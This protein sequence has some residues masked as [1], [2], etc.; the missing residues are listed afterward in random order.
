MGGSFTRSLFFFPTPKCTSNNKKKKGGWRDKERETKKKK[1]TLM[2]TPTTVVGLDLSV[3]SPGIAVATQ[4]EVTKRWSWRLYC[5]AQRKREHGIRFEAPEGA[6]LHVLPALPKVTT[7]GSLL[8]DVGRYTTIA[9][10]LMQHVIA[11]MQDAASTCHV[12]IEGYAFPRREVSGH[13]FKL[14]ELGGVI[15]SQLVA[16]GVQ[17]ITVMTASRWKKLALGNGHASKHDAV[18]WMATHGPRMDILCALRLKATKDGDIPTPAQDVAD[19]AGL[20]LAVTHPLSPPQSSKK[21]RT[22]ARNAS[23]ER[24]NKRHKQ[25]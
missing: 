23:T 19:A 4:D 7:E 10:A 21:K 9:A 8:G 13:S 6:T 2:A 17:H 25:R 14:H 11:P 15:K 12:V 24:P 5:F 20:V 18:T 1:K 22:L 3:R 16:A